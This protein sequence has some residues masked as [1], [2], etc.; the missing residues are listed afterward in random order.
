M[1]G[2]ILALCRFSYL[3]GRGFQVEHG[4][5]AARRAFL[6]D[7]ARLARRWFWFENVALPA[8]IAQTDPDFTLVVMTGAASASR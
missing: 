3:G 6:Y 2:Q 5:L 7:P 4:S 8:F 1:R